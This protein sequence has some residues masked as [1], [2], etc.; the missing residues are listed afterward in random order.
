MALTAVFAGA[1]VQLLTGLFTILGVWV[2]L[3]LL[4]RV[5]KNLPIGKQ[6]PMVK[7]M[8]EALNLFP[9]Q[10]VCN[11][12]PK[13]ADAEKQVL[14][15]IAA[16]GDDNRTIN[17]RYAYLVGLIKTEDSPLPVYFDQVIIQRVLFE[18]KQKYGDVNKRY[19][20]DCRLSVDELFKPLTE[21]GKQEFEHFCIAAP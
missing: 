3:L 21:S 16:P 12:L 17:R 19:F 14:N 11:L 13:L 5:L 20:A 1:L 2:G 6:I 18:Y 8:H 4:C 7:E 9:Q 10:N 15:R